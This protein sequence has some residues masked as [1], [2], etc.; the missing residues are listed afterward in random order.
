MSRY[1]P[2][3]SYKESNEE[4][5]GTI[6]EHWEVKS[7]KSILQERK[8]NNNPIKTT[9]ILSL[10]MYRG[11]IPYSEKGSGGNKAKEDLTAYKLAYPGD[12]VVNSMNVIAGSVGLSKY[13]GAVSPVYYM[14]RPRNKDDR[15]EYFNAIFQSEAFQKSL[16]GLGNG[17]LVKES[18]SSG[19]LN[20]I[21]MRIPMEKLNTVQFPYPSADEQI[22]ITNFLD[23]ETAKIDV[24]IAKQERMIELLNE[25]R[26]AIISHAVTKGLDPN[27]KMKDSGVEWL[28]EVPAHWKIVPLR[29]LGTFQNGI[30][31]G[32][33]YFGSGFPF[34]NYGDVY[35][36]M[37][38]PELAS[39]LANSS[40]E[41]R[42]LY[43]VQK[44]DVFFTRTSETVHDIGMASTCIKTA[45]NAT[46]SGFVIRFRPSD[47]SLFDGFTQYYFR[48]NFPQLFFVKEMN[49]VTRAS[50]GQELLKRLP[51]LLPPESE[52]KQIQVYLDNKTAKIDTLITKSREAIELMKER[53]TA[54]ISAAVTGKIDVRGMV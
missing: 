47:D 10:C 31:K 46:F 5:L 21:R 41:D 9:E 33:E 26:S 30:S 14:L 40:E 52:Q 11:V 23:R 19:K 8:E 7:L 45:S 25:K 13:F 6:P 1:Q 16:F 50:L 3:H 37:T 34:F 15:V 42:N 35:N 39:G 20:T 48:S 27:A 18:E 28:G 29:H 4:W 17:I 43:S 53:R 22:A 38:L 49:L 12:I 54:L 44:G 24:L 32:A 2:Y 51:V 36:N